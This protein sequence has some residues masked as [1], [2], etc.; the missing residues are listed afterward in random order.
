MSWASIAT[1]WKR[2]VPLCLERA[3]VA[4]LD[5]EIMVFDVKGDGNFLESLLPHISKVDRLRLD[6]YPSIEVVT[7]DLPGFFAPPI[8]NLSSLELQQAEEP[9]ELFPPNGFSAPP[10]FQNV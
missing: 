10:V 6:G 4:L 9:A 8:P 3:G 1:V 7:G 5:V 2:L